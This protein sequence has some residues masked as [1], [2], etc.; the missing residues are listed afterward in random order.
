MAV[1]K[2]HRAG[3]Q[4]SK[5][6]GVSN[7]WRL[8]QAM[9][10]SRADVF[11]LRSTRLLAGPCYAFS[12][13]L[14]GR[15][16]FMIANMSNCD[17]EAREGTPPLFNRWYRQAIRRADA[18]AAQTRDQQELMRERF[19]IE[20]RIV[21][22]GIDFARIVPN[23]IDFAGLEPSNGEPGY[24]VLWVGSL[25]PEKQPDALVKI[26]ENLPQLSFAIIGGPGS[27][28]RYYED[29]VAQLRE[30]PNCSYLG[31]VPPDRIAPYYGRARL[32]LNTSIGRGRVSLHEGFPNT[33]LYSWASGT[34]TC[35]LHVDPD[36]AI[37]E[38]GLGIVDAD[39][40]SLGARIAALL[41]D[42]AAYAATR[43]RCRRHVERHHALEKTWAAFAQL[44][45]AMP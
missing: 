3:R 15:F 35:S 29:A 36:G 41:D 13:L 2:A 6:R 8:Y 24:D 7:L 40:D 28:L 33:Y 1:L 27:D 21:P 17:P 11:V 45:E 20:T 22:N 32:Y 5:L 42:G 30:L 4:G 34:P 43:E 16:V 18:V 14:S 23:G 26:A 37:T 9:A 19:G 39:L 31:F 10:A 44:I 25:K 12:R 38:H